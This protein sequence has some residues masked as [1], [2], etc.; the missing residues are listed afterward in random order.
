MRLGVQRLAGKHSIMFVSQRKEMSSV[1]YIMHSC[2]LNWALRE[3]ET[4]R[5]GRSFELNAD[6]SLHSVL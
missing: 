1:S 4:E 5:H 3:T 2:T 6:T